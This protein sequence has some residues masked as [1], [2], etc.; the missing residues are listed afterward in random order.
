MRLQD[1][2]VTNWWAADT[3]L[4]NKIDRPAGYATRIQRREKNIAVVHH[5]TDIV[6]YRRDG[7]ILLDC[8][9]WR[10]KTT[11]ERLN[12]FTPFG[13]EIYQSSGVWYLAIQHEE[14]VYEDGMVL[15]TDPLG[16]VSDQVD[17]DEHKKVVNNLVDRI[18]G[19][20]KLCANSIPLDVPS[21]Q[22]CWYCHLLT[23]EGETLGDSIK[24][25]QHLELHMDE[26]YVVPSL[27][28][29]ALKE[30][31]ADP[32]SHL[33]GCLVFA[34]MTNA[35][36]LSIMA[37]YRETTKELVQRAVARFMKKRFAIGQ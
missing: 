12:V 17:K 11:K 15:S 29:Q 14:H 21:A 4:G 37:T 35:K 30:S 34:D 25:N 26:E 22:D 23:E 10:S 6:T 32:R 24:G 13:V 33:Y 7:T 1:V 20:S 3:Y 31:G 27:V 18:N 28:W 16:V 2:N 5:A 19:Y 9:G 8:N 36:E